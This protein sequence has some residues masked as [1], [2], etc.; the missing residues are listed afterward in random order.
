MISFV[1]DQHYSICMLCREAT[2]TNFIIF[3]LTQLVLEPTVYH[4]LSEQVNHCITNAVLWL[5]VNCERMVDFV[6]K[7]YPLAYSIA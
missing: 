6:E 3:H 1:L 7:H 5:L 4:T 2:N